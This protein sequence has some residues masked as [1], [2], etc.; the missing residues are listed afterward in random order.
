MTG[1]FSPEYSDISPRTP[2]PIEVGE[3]ASR[4]RRRVQLEMGQHVLKIGGDTVLEQ[5][6]T[7]YR[8]LENRLRSSIIGQGQAI[9]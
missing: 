1:E 9:G 3:Q 2:T 5:P 7:G 6:E 4:R 8:K